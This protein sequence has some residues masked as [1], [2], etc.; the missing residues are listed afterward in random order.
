MDAP[1]EARQRSYGC[2][3]WAAGILVVV[4][5]LAVV[6][7]PMLLS[8]TC[9]I[10]YEHLAP[11]RLKTLASAEADFRAND[12][13]WNHINDFWT[14][15]V[16]GLYTMTGSS[17]SYMFATD[18]TRD[19]TIK[20]IELHVAMCDADPRMVPAGGLNQPVEKFGGPRVQEAYWFA[21]LKRDLSATS[22]E[23][24][25][26]QLDTGGDPAMGSCHN[27]TKFGFISFPDSA[28][29]GKTAY[30][31]NDCNTVFRQ[32][33]TV[34]IRRGTANPPGLDQIAPAYLDWPDEKTLKS[35]WSKLD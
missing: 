3:L 11:S 22:A 18:A 26:Y 35:S 1:G 29:M 2:L 15:D 6:I 12:R 8:P 24:T 27:T 30:I 32:L 33:L 5:G 16:K 31:I 4:V 19:T 28:S 17:K 20:L 23:E 25:V 14:G 21:A 9:R 34:P 7:I 10:T 13:D